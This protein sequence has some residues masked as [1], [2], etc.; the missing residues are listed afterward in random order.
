MRMNRPDKKNALTLAMYD[1]MAAALDSADGTIQR[2]AASLIAGVPGAFSRRQ[3]HRR[4]SS[5]RDRRRQDWRAGCRA[6]SMRWLHCEQAAGRRRPRHR[7]RRRHHHAACIAT[8]WSP[9]PT[10]ASPRPSSASAWCRKPPRACSRRALMGHAP[11]LLA[12]GDG[13]PA[14]R[15]RGARL[16][17]SST[18]SCAPG[19]VEAEA[20]KAAREIAALPPQA[21]RGVARG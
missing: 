19:D 15:G 2:F 20:M 7:G 3:R 11:R 14:R 16:P 8:M 13:P 1:A 6:F 10:R 4:I 17:A 21:R 5:S 9:A 18:R 12:A